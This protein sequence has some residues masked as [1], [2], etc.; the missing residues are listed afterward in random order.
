MKVVE[1]KT[2]ERK[3]RRD[4][5][6]TKWASGD[7]DTWVLK[8]VGVFMVVRHYRRLQLSFGL[9]QEGSRTC[10]SDCAATGAVHQCT[11]SVDESSRM[12]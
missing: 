4:E 7:V 8:A 6:G 11:G 12:R 10:T 3:D 1:R 2:G 9:L 5:G